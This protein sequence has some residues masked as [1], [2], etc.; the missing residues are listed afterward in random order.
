MCYSPKHVYYKF[1]LF[2]Y[3]FLW[4]KYRFVRWKHSPRPKSAFTLKKPYINIFNNQVRS[5]QQIFWPCPSLMCLEAI[6]YFFAGTIS[7]P[8]FL[9]RENLT[10][11]FHLHYYIPTSS[12]PKNFTHTRANAP[13]YNRALYAKIFYVMHFNI[14]SKVAKIIF[15]QVFIFRFRGL[16]SALATFS[17]LSAQ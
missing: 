5:D 15:S 6:S 11:N 8:P 3:L 2:C 13:E 9:R 10:F 17:R 12:F 7:P 1:L 4:S 14:E 16:S